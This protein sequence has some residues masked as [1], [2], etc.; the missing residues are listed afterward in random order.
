MVEADEGGILADQEVEAGG[1][2]TILDPQFASPS[3]AGARERERRTFRA[4]E[5]PFATE[6]SDKVSAFE[7]A[8]QFEARDDRGQGFER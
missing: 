6:A 4:D 7:I 1:Q 8:S 2:V 3:D 5:E